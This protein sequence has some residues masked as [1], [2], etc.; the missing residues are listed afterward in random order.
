[1]YFIV[2]LIGYM[3]FGYVQIKVKIDKCKAIPKFQLCVANNTSW[4][5]EKE[6]HSTWH[7]QKAPRGR[8]E[9]QEQRLRSMCRL[10]KIYWSPWSE[11]LSKRRVEHKAEPD[12][13]E[14]T[15]RRS[16]RRRVGNGDPEDSLGGALRPN[17]T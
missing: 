13:R 9:L 2:A 12:N 4:K 8:E 1:M 3:H 6:V 16:R 17:S 10:Q 7:R 15:T 14:L 5:R 11:S